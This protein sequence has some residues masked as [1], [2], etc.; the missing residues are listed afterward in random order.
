MPSTHLHEPRGFCR[1]LHFEQKGPWPHGLNLI[2]SFTFRKHPWHRSSTSSIVSVSV[3]IKGMIGVSILDSST[4]DPHHRLSHPSFQPFAVGGM[5]SYLFFHHQPSQQ[6]LQDR[7]ELRSWL[8][9]HLLP[10]PRVWKTH[11]LSRTWRK[12][13][14]YYCLN[15][16]F[17]YNGFFDVKHLLIVWGDRLGISNHL[18]EDRHQ[19]HSHHTLQKA[20]KSDR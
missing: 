19:Y 6:F 13:R 20:C 7:P 12:F 17:I 14:R 9:F 5:M 16:H 1:V 2:M 18:E 11:L 15:V 8:P 3:W 4:P 10:S